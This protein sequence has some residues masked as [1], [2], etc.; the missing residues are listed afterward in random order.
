MA[1]VV[2]SVVRSVGVVMILTVLSRLMVM[3]SQV[4]YL[5]YFGV[6]AKMDVYSFAITI[7]NV[8]FAGI[9]TA[10]T[11]VVVPI[12]ADKYQIGRKKEAFLFVRQISTLSVGVTVVFSIICILATPYL[13]QFTDFREGEIRTLAIFATRIMFIVMIF[14]A[15]TAIYQG[16][17]QSTGRFVAASLVS[18]PGSIGVIL[19]ILTM[20]ARYNLKGL[21]VATILGLSCQVIILL[22]SMKRIGFDFKPSIN[23]RQGEILKALRLVPPVF[24]GTSAWQ[25]NMVFNATVASWFEGGTTLITLVQN[26]ITSGVMTFI[27]SITA[28]IFPQ[29]TLLF[30]E[31]KLSAFKELFS[32]TVR[33]VLFFLV[34]LSVGLVL[35]GEDFLGL[36]YGR[37]EVTVAD[38]HIAGVLIAF[39]GVGIIG[40]SV[41]EIA[42]RAFYSM[43]DTRT[44]AING[45]VIMLMNVICC[46]LLV[47]WFGVY[48][49]S[50]GYMLSLTFGGV[51]I[52][53]R[54]RKRVGAFE[55]SQMYVFC[56][57][58][59]VSSAF[60]GIGILLSRSTL[61]KIW[62]GAYFR[63][64]LWVFVG[65]VGVGLCT[66]YLCARILR[67]KEVAF[68]EE[69]IL[70]KLKIRNRYK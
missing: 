58:T 35:M 21:L 23:W 30:V 66:Y 55:G 59:L 34:P 2:R 13:I 15:L 9:G 10:L 42:D 61:Q 43:K 39:Y 64:R 37:G 38:I 16:V 11:T 54:L 36:V 6:N 49:I 70:Q 60:M 47:R 12:F 19:Y 53:L 22:P 28:V 33:T 1:N 17:L 45:L 69:R 56:V 25:L 57:K 20:G 29:F 52:V 32:N 41:K 8:L 51:F 63:E 27:F 48:G 31:N 7:P 5:G 26:L 24:I 44:P 3:L 46:L 67:M 40:N 62:E 50:M 65:T 18:L 4:I 14:Y 68:V